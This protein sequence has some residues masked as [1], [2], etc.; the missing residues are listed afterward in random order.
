MN[1]NKIMNEKALEQ[2]R[3]EELSKEIL[4][5]GLKA[6]LLREVADNQKEEF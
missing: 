6:K 2:N 3:N 4:S 5:I 1:L